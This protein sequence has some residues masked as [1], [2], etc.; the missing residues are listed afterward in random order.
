MVNLHWYK[1]ESND[2]FESNLPKPMAAST[3]SKLDVDIRFSYKNKNPCLF[4]TVSQ[5]QA[6]RVNVDPPMTY[7]EKSCKSKKQTNVISLKTGLF[8]KQQINNNII[9]TKN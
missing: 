7:K 4:E 3:Q 8:F 5:G 1:L 6:I 9:I 2:N